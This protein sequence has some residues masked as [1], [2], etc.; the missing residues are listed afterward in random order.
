VATAAVLVDRGIEAGY[1][2]APAAQDRTAHRLGVR[3]MQTLCT[4]YQTDTVL[5]VGDAL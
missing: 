1:D 2:R 3:R 5:A 4:K